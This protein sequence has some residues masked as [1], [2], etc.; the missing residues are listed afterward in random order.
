[1][2]GIYTT[3]CGCL[4]STE[5]WRYHQRRPRWNVLLRT[6]ST[7]RCE[8]YTTLNVFMVSYKTWCA[9]FGAKMPK[10][11]NGTEVDSNL[12]ISPPTRTSMYLRRLC[13]RGQVE[14]HG[15]QSRPRCTYVDFVTAVKS[16]DMASSQDL[17]VPTYTLLPRSSRMTWRPVNTLMYLRRLCYRGQV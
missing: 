2:F 4:T 16:N 11:R 5:V 10:L 1:M 12:L 3:Q 13:Y 14:W 7:Q 6:V 17:D 8:I 9:S 15:V